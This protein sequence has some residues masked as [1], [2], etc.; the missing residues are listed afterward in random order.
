MPRYFLHVH[1]RI[2]HVPDEEGRDFHDLD[3]AMA[4]ALEGIRSL[5]AEELRKG[6]LDLDGR[7]EIADSTGHIVRVVRFAE[8]VELRRSDPA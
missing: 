3:G 6:E 4:A 5:L 1:N 7:I 2:G 8:A